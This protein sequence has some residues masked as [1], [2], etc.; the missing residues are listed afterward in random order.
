MCKT[1]TSLGC[2]PCETA[3]SS[4]STYY[5]PG[6][7]EKKMNQGVH[8]T[9]RSYGANKCD[10]TP[11]IYKH[12]NPTGLVPFGVPNGR[13]E[14][15]RLLLILASHATLTAQNTS[16]SPFCRSLDNHQHENGG[17][18]RRLLPV[19]LADFYHPNEQR[20]LC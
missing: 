16:A 1:I 15:L 11:T 20:A 12:F 6:L 7:S 4:A 9:C 3:N 13:V 10:R 2:N 18:I 17:C 8:F 5:L 19:H 14:E